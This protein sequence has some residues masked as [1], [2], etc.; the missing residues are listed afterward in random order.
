MRFLV[1]VYDDGSVFGIETTDDGGAILRHLAGSREVGKRLSAFVE[2][3]G[4]NTPEGASRLR[5][6]LRLVE[7]A[8]SEREAELKPS[9]S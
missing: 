7:Q 3:L 1:K 8:I 6:G 9:E 4:D 2:I 5:E